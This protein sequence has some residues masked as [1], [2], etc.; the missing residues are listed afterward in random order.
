[1]KI[2]DHYE[3]MRERFW[4]NTEKADGCWNW[5]GQLDRKGYGVMNVGGRKGNM[6]HA[7]RVAYTL[8]IGMFAD[9]LQVL[10][11]CDNK[12]CVNP[13]HLFLGTNADNMRDKITKGRQAKGEGIT[14]SKLTIEKVVEI[15][16][17]Y[18]AGES[19]QPTL[20]REYGVGVATVCQAI[21][22]K[23][24]AHVAEGLDHG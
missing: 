1:V 4:K 13:D 5:T 3:S 7:H 16:R 17:R 12:R 24:W 22:G 19:D 23:T 2:V 10:H 8:V 14:G 11:K 18:A 9:G 20:A 21:S 6:V 15:R